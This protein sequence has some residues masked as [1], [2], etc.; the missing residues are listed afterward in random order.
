MRI[1]EVA[2]A[3]MLSMTRAVVEGI[4][5]DEFFCNGGLI[6]SVLDKLLDELVPGIGHWQI[7]L[8]MDDLGDQ[9]ALARRRDCTELAG[10]FDLAE[11]YLWDV[12]NHLDDYRTFEEG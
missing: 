1:D 6:R 4:R 7:S 10:R 2:T 9:A 8:I 12:L 11:D 5:N 3:E